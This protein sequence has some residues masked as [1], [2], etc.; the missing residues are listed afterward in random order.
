MDPKP[1]WPEPLFGLVTGKIFPHPMHSGRVWV[2]HK[3]DPTRPD[4]WTALVT[5]LAVQELMGSVEVEVMTKLHI[6]ATIKGRRKWHQ[7][8]QHKLHVGK[9]E[10][11]LGGPAVKFWLIKLGS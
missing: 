1:I 2:G 3:P 4:P 11:Q 5:E 10:E 8:V 7:L 6:G 9:K